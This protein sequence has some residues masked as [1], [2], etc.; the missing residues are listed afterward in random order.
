MPKQGL[1]PQGL[2]MAV[3]I[4]ERVPADSAPDIVTRLGTG[5]GAGVLRGSAQTTPIGRSSSLRCGD[6]A[7]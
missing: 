2:T 5:A 7:A 6:G 1:L 4:A 3:D